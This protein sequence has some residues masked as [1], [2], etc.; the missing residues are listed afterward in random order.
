M[1]PFISFMS[2]RSMSLHVEQMRVSASIDSPSLSCRVKRVVGRSSP[3]MPLHSFLLIPHPTTGQQGLSPDMDEARR[4]PETKL[5]PE[6]G[7][8]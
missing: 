2:H 8:E 6:M 4:G 5:T 3:P 1:R 7:D